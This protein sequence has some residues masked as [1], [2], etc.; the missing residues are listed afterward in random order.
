LKDL[1]IRLYKLEMMDEFWKVYER[2][3]DKDTIN[4]AIER[5]WKT[6]KYEDV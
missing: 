2:Y 3:R 1:S 4:L 6:K 5:V